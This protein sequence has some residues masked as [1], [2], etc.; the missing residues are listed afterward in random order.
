MEKILKNYL[1]ETATAALRPK[2]IHNPDSILLA[3]ARTIAATTRKTALC[4]VSTV[5][6]NVLW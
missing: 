3:S 2:S 4:N 6:L 5:V 1:L